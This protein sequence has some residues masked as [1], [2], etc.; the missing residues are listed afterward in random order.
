MALA[1]I[2]IKRALSHSTSAFLGLVFIAVGLGQ[3]DIA[4]M[5]LFAHAT[6]KALLFMSVGGIITTTSNQ[7][8]TEMGGLWSRMPATTTAFVVGSAGIITLM[9]MGMFW[10]LQRWFNGSWSVDR[11]LLAVLMFVN[12]I[13]ALNL[14]RV[15]R[16]VFLGEPQSKT[17]RTPEVI[18]PMALPMVTLTLINLV[19][20][21]VP[22]RWNLW[23]SNVPPLLNND[24][25]VARWGIFLLFLSGLSGFAIGS[26][27]KLRRAWAR[28]TQLSLRF[29][30]DLFAYD[31]YLDRVY[32]V[33]VV[34]AVATLSK[35][36]AWVDRY[37]IDGLVNLVSLAAIFSGNTL[38]Y[39]VSGQSQFYLLTIILGVSVLMGSVLNG[40]WSTVTNYWSSLIGQ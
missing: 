22:I 37:A 34:W 15:F 3:I 36:T 16:L 27:I 13:N 23:L 6:A 19:V 29:L 28:P 35:I 39:N 10:T 1:Q 11:W 31:F 5:I 33:T 4:L 12:C 32:Q 18:W 40:Q 26:T 25:W 38:K 2:D 8:I 20:P 17:R 9:P 7:N 21:A 14:T 30:Q 24:S